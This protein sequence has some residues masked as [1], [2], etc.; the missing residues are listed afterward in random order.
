MTCLWFQLPPP[1]QQTP[2]K[3]SSGG[4]GNSCRGFGL[5]GDHFKEIQVITAD[6]HH[7]WIKRG[8]PDEKEAELFYAV[9]GGS[10]GNFA[11]MTHIRLQ[12]LKSEAHP[13]ARGLRVIAPY[14]NRVMRRLL[15]VGTKG[16]KV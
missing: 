8:T 10:P 13:Y 4:Y 15:Q 12:A 5:F 1:L 3:H 7:R 14:T 6:G 16:R 2:Q 11:I 9:L